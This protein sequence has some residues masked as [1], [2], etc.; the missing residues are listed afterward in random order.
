M[1]SETFV[2]RFYWSRGVAMGGANRI[3]EL[4]NFL[5]DVRGR[6][7]GVRVIIQKRKISIQIFGKKRPIRVNRPGVSDIF[8]KFESKVKHYRVV[9]RGQLM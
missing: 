8:V 1:W 4:G 6:I 7:N 3:G 9:V 2:E 5:I